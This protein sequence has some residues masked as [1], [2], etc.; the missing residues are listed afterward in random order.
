MTT[1]DVYR[2]EKTLIEAR[3]KNGT[4][5]DADLTFLS[6]EGLDLRGMSLASANISGSHFRHVILDGCDLTGIYVQES[7][8]SGSSFRDAVLDTAFFQKT[9]LSRCIMVGAALRGVSLLLCHLEDADFSRADLSQAQILTTNMDGA[10]FTE[11]TLTQACLR[12]S[13]LTHAVFRLTNL[14]GVDFRKTN[15]LDAIYSDVVAQGAIYY[16]KSPWDGAANAQDWKEKM[17]VFDG[18]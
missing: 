16:G 6:V 9:R 17:H 10:N 14:S 11:A 1:L 15:L 3:G 18:E 7:D 13:S 4:L 2:D 8:L 5:V 12:E